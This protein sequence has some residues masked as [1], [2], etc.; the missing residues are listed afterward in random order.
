MPAQITGRI[1]EDINRNGVYESEID[2]PIS[3]A[4]VLLD[5]G[6]E[7]CR[8][9]QSLEDGSYN[10]SITQPGIY[11]VYETAIDFG[12]ACPPSRVGQPVGYTASTTYRR[13]TVT[14]T[15]ADIL[16]N[17]IIESGNFG[18]ENNRNTFNSP[19]HEIQFAT[20]IDDFT[21]AFSNNDASRSL[22]EWR[23]IS[24]KMVVSAIGYNALDHFLYGHNEYG[25]IRIDSNL[26]AT[27]LPKPKPIQSMYTHGGIET[28]GLQYLYEQN[29]LRFYRVQLDPGSPNYLMLVN[30]DGTL[31]VGSPRGTMFLG[32][33][34]NQKLI[35]N[36]QSIE[37]VKSQ[38]EQ[39]NT[40]R[41]EVNANVLSPSIEVVKTS[42]A[43]A[44]VV[45]DLFTYMITVRNSGDVT[46]TSVVATDMLPIGITVKAIKLDG[47]NIGGDLSIGINIGDLAIG[48][49]KVIVIELMLENNIAVNSYQN[50]VSV[51]GNAVVAPG[52]PPIPV[53]QA[54]TDPDTLLFYNP[55]LRLY[56][57]ADQSIVVEGDKV[58]YTITATNEAS[59]LLENTDFIDV[60]ISDLLT[61]ELE[62][63]RGSVTVNDVCMPEDNILS[64]VSIGSLAVG[65]TKEVKF[66]AKIGKLVSPTIENQSQGKFIYILPSLERRESCEVSNTCIVDAVKVN[67]IV[68][69]RAEAEEVLLGE[70]FTY[71][72]KVCNNGQVV[73]NNIILKDYLPN[74]VRLVPGSFKVNGLVMQNIDIQKGVNIG[75]LETGKCINVEYKVKVISGSFCCYI[76]NEAE[77][78]YSYRLANGATGTRR[79]MG[80]HS[81]TKTKVGM[82]MFKQLSVE[83]NLQIPSAKPDIEAINY[84]EG[85]IKILHTQLIR[86]PRGV[87]QEGQV[88]TGYKL[89]V[90]GVVEIVIEYTALE[91]TQ[92]VHAAH[93]CIPFS[94]FIVLPENYS[95]GTHAEVVGEI[96]DVYYKALDFRNLF[97]NITTLINIKSLNCCC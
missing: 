29:D 23:Y 25:T 75:D 81:M 41:N 59:A 82:T 94:S 96:E 83:T 55:S 49:T 77:V 51:V 87:S 89:M 38:P 76:T 92:S 73:A 5:D 24:P 10:F 62:F 43:S 20:P 42:K 53:E 44:V 11:T 50:T 17:A 40:T 13:S 14:V 47:V 33:E 22:N 35:L 69:K 95:I 54:G 90:H 72:I 7:A 9:V 80:V 85:K 21:K 86:T 78:E 64:G 12:T 67:V 19:P 56:K 28:N 61:P 36:K 37:H 32:S 15:A 79:G 27:L 4:Y 30:E 2:L 60:I 91:E 88:L 66:K 71:D 18:H 63:I 84:A 46:L 26:E 65:E 48:Q 97:V 52:Q 16:G 34:M 8:G 93:Y 70:T 31:D 1:F 45:G 68:E 57:A 6:K 74:Q 3:G 39:G 58:T